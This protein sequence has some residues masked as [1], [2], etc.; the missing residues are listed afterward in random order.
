MLSV[1]ST[2]DGYYSILIKILGCSKC[3]KT[4]PRSSEN[5]ADYSGF[6]CDSWVA[7]D[8]K[9]VSE[10][11]INIL[12]QAKT[13]TELRELESSEGVRY[14]QLN[15]SSEIFVTHRGVVGNGNFDYCQCRKS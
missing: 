10:Y 7:R 13:K 4:F 1:E 2:L 8:G 14:I 6:D 12:S 11:A 9:M 15:V 5:H 3:L